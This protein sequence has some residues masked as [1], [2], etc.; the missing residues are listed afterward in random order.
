MAYLLPISTDPLDSPSHSLLHRIITVD[1]AAAEQSLKIDSSSNAIISGGVQVETSFTGKQIA[2]PANPSAG[3]NKAYFKSGDR[4]YLLTSGGT[5]SLVGN[6][7]GSTG[8]TDNAIL[9]A[10]GTGTTTVQSTGITIDDS[11]NIVLPAVVANDQ[12][13]ILYRGSAR[14][15]HSYYPTNA[16]GGNVF[17]GSNAGNFTMT[18]DVGESWEASNLIGIGAS[19]LS[20]ITQGYLLVAIGINAYASQT[21]GSAGTAVGHYAFDKNTQAAGTA[22]G[23]Q[24]GRYV[25][26]YG[27]TLVGQNAGLGVNATSTYTYATCLGA[28]AGLALTTG[29]PSGIYIGTYAGSNVTSGTQNIII[30]TNT[31]AGTAATTTTGG[32]NI[33]IG[34]GSDV[35]ANNASNEMNIGDVVYAT[36][37]Y[38]TGKVGIGVTN[39]NITARLHLPAGTT[40]A[41][42]APL[43][44]T[45]GSLMSSP[46][47]GAME[48]LTDAYYLTI[49]T[50]TARQQIVT[51]TN[52]VTMTNKTLTSPT[53]TTPVLGTPSS[54]TLTNCTGL[55]IA[56]LVASTSTAIGVGSIELGHASDTTI[57]R[58]S[59]GVISVEGVTVPTI[60]STSTFTNKR[61]TKRTGTTTSSA[62]PTINTDNVDFYSLTAQAVDITSFTTNLSGTPTEGQ[63]LWIAITGTAARAITWGASF[64][65]STVTLPTT[66]VTTARL[67]VGFVWNT[68]T[69][70]WRCIAAV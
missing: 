19:A 63:S 67:D 53:L 25:V 16:S 33:I 68:V 51:D 4:L 59:A 28:F 57:A 43:K 34:N 61:I 17:I 36:G 14:W 39:A 62:T 66:T 26:G 47:A 54:G 5:E 20:S 24:A 18:A 10:D 52:T 1:S 32:S 2:T 3:Y 23:Y 58:V 7:S 55:P 6:I 44:F 69:S 30:A 11:D 49:T 22:I 9:R 40:S 56:G 46:E 41:A 27:N 31:T 29:A 13:G 50:G 42:S 38:G 37:L 65:S 15:M 35:S 45:S 8:S 60:S 48:F 70:K 12:K 64:E 21:T